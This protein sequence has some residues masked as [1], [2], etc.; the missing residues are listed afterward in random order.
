MH[1]LKQRTCG[2]HSNKHSKYSNKPTLCIALDSQFS[3]KA[4]YAFLEAE[5]MWLS[6][7]IPRLE[8]LIEFHAAM[9]SKMKVIYQASYPLRI[10]KVI[11]FGN[12]DN[13]F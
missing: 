5:N 2:F 4:G 1:F 10:E 3:S 9:I 8:F 6:L 7:H 13:F 11:I 12:F